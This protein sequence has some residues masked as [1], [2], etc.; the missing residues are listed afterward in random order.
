MR[1]NRTANGRLNL[2]V[3]DDMDY[4]VARRVA[5]AIL[6]T[7]SGRRGTSLVDVDGTSWLDLEIMG[8]TVTVHV[9]RYLGVSVY[10]VD[11]AADGVILDV[12]NY[13]G[14]NAAQLGIEL[15]K[16]A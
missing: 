8:S 14:A 10:A 3:S 2:D 9:Q 7:F 1:L 11:E 15:N 6:A 12:A 13:L 16:K 5:A 4:E